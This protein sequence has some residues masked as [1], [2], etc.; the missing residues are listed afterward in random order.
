MATVPGKA[1]VWSSSVEHLSLQLPNI[2]EIQAFSKVIIKRLTDSVLL[3]AE[4][5]RRLHDNPPPARYHDH[6]PPARTGILHTSHNQQHA[7]SMGYR[8][9][10]EDVISQYKSL[11]A[12]L[13]G[14][15]N[16]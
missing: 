14:K 6:T 7:R 13:V 9:A 8:E 4:L 5:D 12:Q 10:N 11:S 1:A 3:N 2:H 15:K 16:K